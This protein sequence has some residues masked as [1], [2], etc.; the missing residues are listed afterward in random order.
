MDYFS[1]VFEMHFTLSWKLFLWYQNTTLA[2]ICYHYA[3]I[4]IHPI[5]FADKLAGFYHLIWSNIIKQKDGRILFDEVVGHIWQNPAETRSSLFLLGLL[6]SSCC[7]VI[8]PPRQV[9]LFK[10]TVFLIISII[11]I[12]NFIRLGYFSS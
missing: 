7:L 11:F 2:S 9:E 3:R 5:I 4:Y 1:F 8:F 6:T 12:L 10:L